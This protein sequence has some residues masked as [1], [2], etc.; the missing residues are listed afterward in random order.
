MAAREEVKAA[1]A[2]AE[3]ARTQDGTAVQPQRGVCC[4]LVAPL[5]LNRFPSVVFVRL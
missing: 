1:L 3:V 4:P 2:A 5:P